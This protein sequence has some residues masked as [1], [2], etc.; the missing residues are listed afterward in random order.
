MVS[1]SGCGVHQAAH[2]GREARAAG[3]QA[4]GP[5]EELAGERGEVDPEDVLGL[6]AAPGLAEL[7]GR[8]GG[9]AGVGGDEDGVD[10]PGGDAG[11]EGKA[12]VGE[13]AGEAPNHP[14]LVGPPSA[15][16]GEHESEIA[17]AHRPV[18]T[19]LA[20]RPAAVA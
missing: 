12:K 15:A 4:G 18:P 2:G 9:G 8:L 20:R 1:R 6:E 13:P 14:S 3:N 16:A 11:D 7:L 17:P 10:G 19:P 5:A